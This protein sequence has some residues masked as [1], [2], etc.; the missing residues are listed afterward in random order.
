MRDLARNSWKR[1]YNCR[2]VGVLVR[3]AQKWR[4]TTFKIGYV[5]KALSC[6]NESLFSGIS[7]LWEN[8]W[9][10]GP[11]GMWVKT[12]YS[13][14][15]KI[16]RSH[17]LCH[18]HTYTHTHTRTHCRDSARLKEHQNMWD[19]PGC[20]FIVGNLVQCFIFPFILLPMP[21]WC[22]L[23]S[24]HLESL[25]SVKTLMQRGNRQAAVLS[26]PLSNCHAHFN[27]HK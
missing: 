22:K 6:W 14:Q 7:V 12:Q 16:F 26:V 4:M 23:V 25:F 9:S 10:Q 13:T 18:K 8:R 3:M 5:G 27:R 15:T 2:Q 19:Q 21:A 24:P 17:T 11:K 20:E 1:F